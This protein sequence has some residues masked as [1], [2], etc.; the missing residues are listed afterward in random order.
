MTLARHRFNGYEVVDSSSDPVRSVLGEGTKMK[1]GTDVDTAIVLG[2][3]VLMSTNIENHERLQ[4]RRKT[5]IQRMAGG[6]ADKLKQEG[7]RSGMHVFE[8]HRDT[9][10]GKAGEMTAKEHNRLMHHA[11]RG[12]KSALSELERLN[13]G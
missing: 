4:R 12:D 5:R 1:K 9:M 6:V 2:D 10:S 8:E 13:K 3:M 7:Q 11:E